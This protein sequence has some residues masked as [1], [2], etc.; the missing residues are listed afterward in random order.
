MCDKCKR[1]LANM[2]ATINAAEFYYSGLGDLL[3]MANPGNPNLETGKLLADWLNEN[4]P[5]KFANPMQVLDDKAREI[6][7]AYNA[8]VELMRGG[9]M[10]H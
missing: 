2:D 7:A 5:S 6:V 3:A 8:N 4:P 1:G 10:I 9:D